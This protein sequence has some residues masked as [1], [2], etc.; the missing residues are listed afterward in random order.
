LIEVFFHVLFSFI[1]SLSINLPLQLGNLLSVFFF[2]AFQTLLQLVYRLST[3]LIP[4]FLFASFLFFRENLIAF[5]LPQSLLQ[6]LQLFSV[7]CQQAFLLL[8]Q[9]AH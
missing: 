5:L 8:L 4:G 9:L 1:L 7:A 2:R 3:L 6:L